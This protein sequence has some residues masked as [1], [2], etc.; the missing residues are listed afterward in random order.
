M[1]KFFLVVLQALHLMTSD[2]KK[3]IAASL[4]VTEKILGVLQLPT[5]DNVL[6]VISPDL[7]KVIP[8]IE[9][10][11]SKAITAMNSADKNVDVLAIAGE[12][13]IDKIEAQLNAFMLAWQ[14][15][16]PLV[17]K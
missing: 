1:K 14:K 15:E 2:A 6:S 17:Q 8:G 11:L 13:E 3:I 5:I 12:T 4:E 16:T 9:L 7:A 10:A